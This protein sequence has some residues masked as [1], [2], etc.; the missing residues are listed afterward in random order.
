MEGSCGLKKRTPNFLV[1]ER[2]RNRKMRIG[3]TEQH[4][5]FMD[6]L[7]E[8][9]SFWDI[10]V[11]NLF[12]LVPKQAQKGCV[13]RP[14]ACYINRLFSSSFVAMICLHELAVFL[15]LPKKKHM[16]YG[17]RFPTLKRHN[18]K[19]PR[20]R[21]SSRRSSLGDDLRGGSN[22][23]PWDDM[24]SMASR[25]R[26]FCH[27]RIS[28]LVKNRYTVTLM[29]NIAGW[30]MPTIFFVDV[31]PEIQDGDVPGASYVCCS[32]RVFVEIGLPSRQGFWGYNSLFFGKWFGIPIPWRY[33]ETQKVSG[34][35]PK[36][37]LFGGYVSFRQCMNDW[38]HECNTVQCQFSNMCDSITSILVNCLTCDFIW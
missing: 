37:N 1:S 18:R 9:I 23:E 34:S 24:P 6:R 31:F 21:E 35:S 25:D 7:L 32:R 20:F 5:D 16:T 17:H 19:L 2:K 26:V 38:I 33:A 4:Q 29:K 8:G 11:R 36:H 12:A 10:S 30:K 28:H 22:S 13:V 15:V 14:R 3:L 27:T